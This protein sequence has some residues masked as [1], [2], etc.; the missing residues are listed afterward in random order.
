MAYTYYYIRMKQSPK[1]YFCD[2]END[3]HLLQRRVDLIHSAAVQL[4]RNNL[5]K[6]DK[7][8]GNFQTTVLGKIASHYYIKHAS[9]SIYNE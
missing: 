7:K 3:P 6:Y 2:T 4:D 1:T 8:S 9:I 5:I